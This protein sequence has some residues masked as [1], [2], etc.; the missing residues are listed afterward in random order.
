MT[1]TGVPGK[2]AGDQASPDTGC[3]WASDQVGM[4]M[5]AGAERGVA[6][7]CVWKDPAGSSVEEELVGREKEGGSMLTKVFNKPV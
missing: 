5:M 6:Y 7:T 3:V 1:H 4:E 2:L